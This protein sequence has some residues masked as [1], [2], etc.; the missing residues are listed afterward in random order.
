MFPSYDSLHQTFSLMLLYVVNLFDV[1]GIPRL[2]TTDSLTPDK[3]GIGNNDSLIIRVLLLLYP[4]SNKMEWEFT[5]N[6]NESHVIKNNTP[7]YKI[8]SITSDNE[9]NITLFKQNV[10]ERDFGNYTLTVANSVG[11]FTKTYR[12]NGASK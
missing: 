12:V 7:G 9:Q 5:W 6:N 2:F 3:I 11:T 8:T 1:L 10:S 4:P